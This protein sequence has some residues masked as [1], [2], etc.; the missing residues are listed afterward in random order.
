ML[1]SPPGSRNR[2]CPILYT[3]PGDHPKLCTCPATEISAMTR[4][5]ITPFNPT[6]SDRLDVMKLIADSENFDGYRP[7]NNQSWL[8]LS[9]HT[10]SGTRYSATGAAWGYLAKD[11][12]NGQPCGYVHISTANQG[13]AIEIAMSPACR[14]DYFEIAS[15]LARGLLC[16]YARAFAGHIWGILVAVYGDFS[17]SAVGFIYPFGPRAA[18]FGNAGWICEAMTRST[19]YEQALS[20]TL[21][22]SSYPLEVWLRNCS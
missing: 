19:T 16:P 9:H 8:K 1:V 2:C 11:T 3:K 21:E 18:F 6:G 10:E 17:V 7:L 15:T 20:C 12:Q 13:S 4:F 5:E 14:S 22:P